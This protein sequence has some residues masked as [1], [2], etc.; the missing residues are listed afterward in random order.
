M[1]GKQLEVVVEHYV[2]L[3]KLIKGSDLVVSHCGAGTLLE[4][5]RSDHAHHIAVVN[6][7]LMDNH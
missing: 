5:L 3:E 7:T 4:G 2:I 1:F 6:E